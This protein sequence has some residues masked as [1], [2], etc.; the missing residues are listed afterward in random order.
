LKKHHLIFPVALVAVLLTAILLPF[1]TTIE[2]GHEFVSM[3]IRPA[4]AAD[5]YFGLNSGTT[6][7]AGVANYLVAQNFKNTVSTGTLTKLEF[8]IEDTTPTGSVRLGVYNG[9]WNLLLDAGTVVLAN[10]WNVISGL[11]LP[12]YLNQ[13]YWLAYVMSGA[14]TLRYTTYLS[15]TQLYRSFTY[16]PLPN[17]FDGSP[18][19]GADQFVMRAYVTGTSSDGYFGLGMGTGEGGE[20]GNYLFGMRWQ[21]TVGT[22]TLTKLEFYIHDSTPTGNVRLGVYA[23]SSSN[24]G[25]LLLDAGAVALTDGW[26]VISSLSLA[27]TLNTWYWLAFDMSASNTLRY[28]AGASNSMAYRSYAYGALPNPFGSPSYVSNQYVVVAYVTIAATSITNTP[29]SKAFGILEDSATHWSKGSAPTFPVDDSECFFTLT[30]N[31]SVAVNLTANATNPT[32]GIG[33]TCV[34]SAPGA[35]QIRVSIYTEGDGSSDNTTIKSG[36]N[37]SIYSNLASSAEL[38]WEVKLEIG[39]STETP[40]TQKTFTIKIIAATA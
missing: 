9:S 27:V 22:G 34:D 10:G 35:N 31:G 7:Y 1:A 15:Q 36:V 13:W 20:N 24:P 3:G 18:S 8:Y 33:A 19:W 29:S 4:M 40:P 5:G 11:S 37:R 23:D 14:N 6:L 2:V 25:D 17:P 28:A 30:N 21:D 16:G 12:V 26:N 38:G 39:T 32:G